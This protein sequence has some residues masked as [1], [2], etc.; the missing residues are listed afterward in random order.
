MLYLVIVLLFTLYYRSDAYSIELE[1]GDE[2]CFTIYAATGTPVSGSFEVISEDADP[3]EVRVNGPKGMLHYESSSD[4]DDLREDGAGSGDAFQFDADMDGEYSMCLTNNNENSNDG[5]KRI[6]AFNF[7]TTNS[8]QRDYEY[9][10]LASELEAL[11]QGLDS[12]KDHHAYM[13]QRENMHKQS[14]ESINLK[15]LCWTVLESIMLISMTVWQLGYI[16]SFF[17]TKRRI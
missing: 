12:L 2:E 5:R 3:V 11:Q 7:R 4:G 13:N 9:N 8:A 14:I 15:V 1:A 10:G 16:R 6:L 17:E